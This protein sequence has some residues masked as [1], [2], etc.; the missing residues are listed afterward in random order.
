MEQLVND[1]VSL[2]EYVQAKQLDV[3]VLKVF[4]TERLFVECFDHFPMVEGKACLNHE[5]PLLITLMILIV[6][7]EENIVELDWICN[8]VDILS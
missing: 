5:S 7:P 4:D 1:R 2:R 3:I 8:L 6:D